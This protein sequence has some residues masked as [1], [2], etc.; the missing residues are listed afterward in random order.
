MAGGGSRF[1]KAGYKD[2]KPLIPV[3]GEPMIQVV[4]ENIAVPGAHF[5]FVVQKDHYNAYNRGA[6]LQK[7]AP[8]C[9][10][11]QIDEITEV[12]ACT[13]LKAK[14]L[15]DS[16][17]PLM[18]AN[19]DQFLEWDAEEFV[20]AISR[21]GGGADGAVSTFIKD[22]PDVKWSY[23]KP[24]ADGY[25]TG[26]QEK[27]PISNITTTTTAIRRARSQLYLGHDGPELTITQGDLEQRAGHLWC[28]AKNMHALG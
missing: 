23:A 6:R 9:D 25:I 28:H 5:I 12:A 22:E 14:K 7:M 3:F 18:T 2:P 1:A 10:I 24:D 11:I 13:I 27:K 8:G 15:I 26:I 4:I 17:V 19:S 16:D 21:A 20:A